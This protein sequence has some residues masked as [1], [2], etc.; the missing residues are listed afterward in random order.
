MGMTFS[1]TR[2]SLPVIEC[3]AKASEPVRFAAEELKRYLEQ[4]LGVDLPNSGDPSGPRIIVEETDDQDLGDEGFEISRDTNTLRIRGGGPAGAVYGVYEFLRRYAGCQFSGLGP[5]GEYVPTL[6]EITMG[7]SRLRMKPQLWYRAL[8]F[9][10]LEDF[11][12]MVNRMDW[13]AKNGLNYVMVHPLPDLP[14]F[15]VTTSVDPASGNIIADGP[16][17]MFTNA[18]FREHLLPEVKKRGLKL[19]MNHHNLFYWLP[20]ERYFDEHPEWYALVDGE[21]RKE[22]RQL[23]LCTSNQAAVDT[24]IANMLT[25]LREN[26]EAKIVGLIPEDGIGMCQCDEC[27]KLDYHPDDAFKP[28]INYRKPEGENKSKIRRYALLLNQAAR[29]IR[30]EF[31]EVL[32]GAAAYVDIQWPPREVVLEPNI[33]PWVAIYWRCAAHLLSPSPES[34][35][36]NRFFYD[37]LQQWRQAHRGKLILYE[38][39]M[40][41]GA[42]LGMPYPIAEVI[43][44]EWPRLKQLGI[45]GAT[46]QSMAVD[47]NTCALNYLAFARH[48]WHD[49]V[50]YESLLDDFLLGMF[51][52]AAEEIRPIYQ[53]F[54]QQLKRVET[55]G[56]SSPYLQYNPKDKSVL[57]CFWPDAKN[58]AYLTERKEFPFIF[59]QIERALK[60]ASNEREVRQLENFRNVARYWQIG[61]GITEA[62]HLM[63]QAEERGDT[64]QAISL[65]AE[66]IEKYD[67][68]LS[69]IEA[70]PPKGWIRNPE[71]WRTGVPPHNL[72]QLKAK[73]DALSER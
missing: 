26:P 62:A 41:M 69:A 27:R 11:S 14:D 64:A 21:R 51:G 13:M 72:S 49:Q 63:A 46:I 48:G 57:A 56:P 37:V 15:E 10:R 32:V 39:Y 67:R 52:S 5:D 45:D 70:L 58:I 24:M 20:P 38:Y 6:D 50:D 36:I 23:S 33:V 66:A 35:Q 8:Q 28:L 12:L 61:A 30:E 17:N 54:Q 40:G 22:R 73:L 7:D 68:D 18:W 2:K 3:D 42:Q 60:R 55:E 19:D 71:R 44:R 4:I 29:A 53:E 16:H 1:V 34:C 9:S 31:P 43:C 25:Y 65:A 47:H 59:E